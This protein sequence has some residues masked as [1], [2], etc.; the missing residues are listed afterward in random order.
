MAVLPTGSRKDA[1]RRTDISSHN[2]KSKKR[3]GA[4]STG[5]QEAASEEHGVTTEVGTFTGP[6]VTGANTFCC[7]VRH[8]E[9]GL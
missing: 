3:R 9:E 7:V 6:S 8:C 2:E 4:E 1:R 5:R